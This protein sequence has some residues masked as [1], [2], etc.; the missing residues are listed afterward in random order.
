VSES[1][2]VDAVYE[3]AS[4]ANRDTGSAAFALAGAIAFAAQPAWPRAANSS[5]TSA[6]SPTEEVVRCVGGGN[7][8]MRI[9][10]SKAASQSARKA[11]RGASANK[12]S[13]HVPARKAIKLSARRP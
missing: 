10:A 12:S 7:A 4:M 13:R 11:V 8:R 1:D 5:S 2:L 9:V 6:I 3:S